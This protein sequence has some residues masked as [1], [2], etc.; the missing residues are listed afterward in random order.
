[1]PAKTIDE[2]IGTFPP[3]VQK[4]LQKM[5][6]VIHNATPHAQEKISYGIP[7]FFLEGNLVH[8]AGYKKHIGFYP[9]PSGIEAFSEQLSTYESAKGS[10]KFPLDKPMPWDLVSEIVA[11]RVKENLAKAAGDKK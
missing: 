11:F 9:E 4:I 2:Y 3:E 8:F 7:T 6:E 1:M 10:V 5:R